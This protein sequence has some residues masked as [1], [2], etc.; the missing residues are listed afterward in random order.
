VAGEVNE[1]LIV[2]EGAPGHATAV[3]QLEEGRLQLQVTCQPTRV[4]W[5]FSRTVNA[6][7]Q[8]PGQQ[9][10]VPEIFS[11]AEPVDVA[12]D[13]LLR[14]IGSWLPKATSCVRLAVGC[15][16]HI[17]V[18][19]KDDGYR[20]LQKYLPTMQLDAIGSSDFSYQINRP[21]PSH[22]V[23]DGLIINRLSQWGVITMTLQTQ[24]SLASANVLQ[25]TPPPLQPQPQPQ[26]LPLQFTMKPV[27]YARAITDVSTA[28]E[29]SKDLPAEK[30]PELLSELC[31][32]SVEIFGVGDVP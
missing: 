6:T 19:N 4:D 21:R 32:L 8:L 15:S 24:A 9:A 31:S 23:A 11:G 30:I 7:F 25:S 26:T 13:T 17:F 27:L 14:R 10:S 28:A 1:N 18:A 12:L 29:N 2:T 22:V 5:L 20:V 16:G 3:G